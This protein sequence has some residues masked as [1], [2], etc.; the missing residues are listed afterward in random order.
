MKEKM[1]VPVWEK[2][3]LTV[4]EATEYFGIGAHKIREL[5]DGEKNPY[6]VWV[7]TRRLVK[8]RPFQNMIEGM[9]SI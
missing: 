1:I 6:V 8:R 9:F 7:G 2:V 4:D 5:T 3:L